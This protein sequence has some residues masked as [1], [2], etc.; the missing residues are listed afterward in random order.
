MGSL[1]QTPASPN[2]LQLVPSGIHTLY[3]PNLYMLVSQLFQVTSPFFLISLPLSVLYFISLS[4]P[5]FLPFFISA[6]S[7]LFC[8]ILS[9]KYSQENSSGHF[10]CPR[11]ISPACTHSCQG[12]S[13]LII[14]F[15]RN[16]YLSFLTFLWE[17]FTTNGHGHHPDMLYICG[18][19][20]V[21]PDYQ[22]QQYSRIS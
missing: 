8:Q 9:L 14:L 2:P 22:S 11:L 15:C 16:L 4:F 7:F 18:S 20:T 21:A 10:L 5:L 3:F 19:Q 1:V 17:E 12:P 6:F 13:T